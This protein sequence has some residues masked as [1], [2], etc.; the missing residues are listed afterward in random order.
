MGR[1]KWQYT[2]HCDTLLEQLLLLWF[3]C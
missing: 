3:Y 2:L 1:Q